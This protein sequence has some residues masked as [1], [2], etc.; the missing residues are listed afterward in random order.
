VAYFEKWGDEILEVKY[1]GPGIS[2]QFIPSGVLSQSA[3]AANARV[4]RGTKSESEGLLEE[5]LAGGDVVVHTYPNPVRDVLHVAFGEERSV[6]VMFVNNFGNTVHTLDTREQHIRIDLRD[7][8]IKDGIFML[9]IVDT[10]TNQ[11]LCSRK[12]IRR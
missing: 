4:F 6:K 12:M 2:K 1:E 11:M 7:L 10:E 5:K 3:E 8:R 9:T